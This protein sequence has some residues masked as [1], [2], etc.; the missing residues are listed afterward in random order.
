MKND[1]NIIVLLI[2]G[3]AV[4]SFLGALF[5]TLRIIKIK[6]V[7]ALQAMSLQ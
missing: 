4:I 6:P 7:E 3:I 5:P 2:T 1:W